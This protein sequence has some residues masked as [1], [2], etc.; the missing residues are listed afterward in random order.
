MTG[1]LTP[2]KDIGMRVPDRIAN[3]VGFVSHDTP[4]NVKYGGT[5]FL[6]GVRGAH[7]NAYLHLVTA[8][9]VAEKIDPG[10]FILG[11]NSRKGGKILVRSGDVKW[12]YHPTEKSSVDVAATIFGVDQISEY[13]LEWI[14]ESIFATNERIAEY[15][16]GIGDELT[17]VGLFTRFSGTSRHFPIIRTGSIAMMP[18][19]KVPLRNFGSAEVYLA[20]GRSI[21]GLS[22]S[23]VFVRNTM[24]LPPKRNEKGELL[25]LFGLG[26]F[27]FLGLMHGHWDVEDVGFKQSE[28]AEA[29]NMGIS[30]VVPAKKILEVLY[31][32]EL[33]EMRKEYD[34]RI[35]QENAPVADSELGNQPKPFTRDDFEDALRKAGRRVKTDK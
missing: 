34:E 13:A 31:H 32:P 23:P 3:C 12:W 27:H 25:Q 24:A 5:A 28:Q 4:E 9:H 35:A 30:A 7:D 8:Q 26:G 1:Y 15:D 17:I 2:P 18:T 16:I 10:P 20:E 33:I 21:G 29:V 11:M 22:G 6:V 19:D 14:P